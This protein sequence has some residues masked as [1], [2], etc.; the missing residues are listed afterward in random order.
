MKGGSAPLLI[1]GAHISS[2]I[3]ATCSQ[4]GVQ[5]FHAIFALGEN[6]IRICT[7]GILPNN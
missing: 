7:M 2:F 4:L 5:I 3:M 6:A 1:T